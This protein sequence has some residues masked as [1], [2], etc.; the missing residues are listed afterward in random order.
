V[1]ADGKKRNGR[2]SGTQLLKYFQ[3]NAGE[4]EVL[5]ECA[6]GT[7]LRRLIDSAVAPEA[8][9]ITTISLNTHCPEKWLMVDRNARQAP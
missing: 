6:R 4:E 5:V 3:Q 7:G 9:T 1:Y 2:I 8:E